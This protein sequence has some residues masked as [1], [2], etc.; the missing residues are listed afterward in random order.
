MQNLNCVEIL[1]MDGMLE[2]ELRPMSILRMKNHTGVE[3]VTENLPEVEESKDTVN[4]IIKSTPKVTTGD[5]D[6]LVRSSSS[7]NSKKLNK[8]YQYSDSSSDSG[9]QW[10][11][12]ETCQRKNKCGDSVHIKRRKRR[13]RPSDPK[14]KAMK[15]KAADIE[16]SLRRSY[17]N[18]SASSLSDDSNNKESDAIVTQLTSQSLRDLAISEHGLISDE[19]RRRAWPQLVRVDMLTETCVLPTQ[20]EVEAHKSYRQVV[21]DVDRSLKRFPPGIAEE[22]R[23]DLQDQLTRL[24]VRVL[25]KHPHLNYYQGYHDVAITFLLVV[26]EELG[27]HI[28]E[29]LSAG[30]QLREFMTP[31][32]ERTTYLLHFMYPVIKQECPELHAYLEES[33][34]GTIFALPWLITWFSHVLP[35]YQDVVRIFDFF[36]AHSQSPMM[37]VYLATAIVLHRQN[38]ILMSGPENC[39][40]AYVH[41]LLSRIP[42]SDTFPIE[43]LLVSAQKLHEKYPPTS[44]EKEVKARLKKLDDELKKMQQKRED[45]KKRLQKSYNGGSTE[46]GSDD[47][48]YRNFI[49]RTG[50]LLAFAAP[51]VVGVVVWRY[52]YHVKDSFPI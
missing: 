28:V 14:S 42:I 3:S 43:K 34:V 30:K 6:H 26:G 50:K 8:K 9:S 21:M 51:I 41:A 37:P 44:I 35:N 47:G 45:I 29:R 5:K 15:Q 25:M 16:K 23:P 40:M 39:D 48:H 24:I 52:L 22:E 31:T 36:L 19:L 17:N 20:E 33:E 10:N 2:D 7:D 1:T 49:S 38:E 4:D 18:P 11:G 12:S 13:K 46:D 32:M 27:F